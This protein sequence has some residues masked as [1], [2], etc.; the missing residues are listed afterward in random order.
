MTRW[1]YFTD[2][3][4]TPELDQR[5]ASAGME[6]WELV[7]AHRHREVLTV[8]TPGEDGQQRVQRQDV[9]G[10]DVIFKRPAR[11]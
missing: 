11:D 10:F 5:L 7:T 8:V 1:E 3:V 6:G 4:P 2:S 9:D